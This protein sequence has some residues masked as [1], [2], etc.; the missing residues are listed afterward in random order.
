MTD[1]DP[2]SRALLARARDARGPD[3]A[4]VARLRAKIGAAHATVGLTGAARL[5]T[6]LGLTT[7]K[8][9]VLGMGVL[10]VGSIGVVLHHGE[11]PHAASAP[12]PPRRM[13]PAP[14]PRPAVVA[15]VPEV[16]EVPVIEPTRRPMP[17]VTNVRPMPRKLGSLP[18]RP[19]PHATL[20][21]ETELVDLATAAMRTGDLAGL[22]STVLLYANETDGVGQLAEDI[23]AIEVEALCRA[24][25][26]DAPTR[27]AA[28]DAR[29]PHAGQRH[30]LTAAC[31]GL[32]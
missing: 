9:L 13:A 31:K 16:P 1:L 30:R 7:T 26:F 18:P 24:N 22:R 15:E 3:M 21:R 17:A 25:D 32:P 10:T 29:W 27:L 23:D 5:A 14:A 11:G 6:K 2:D 8:L 4:T 12:A 28:F 20:A 19:R